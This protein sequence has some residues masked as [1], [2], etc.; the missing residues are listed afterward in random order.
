MSKLSKRS[1]KRV[2]NVAKTCRK[3]SL[4]CVENVSKTCRK[5]LKDM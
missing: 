1:L 3:S 5:C 2:E 4:K